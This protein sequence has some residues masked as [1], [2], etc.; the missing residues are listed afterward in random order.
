MVPTVDP[1]NHWHR[2]EMARKLAW[3][4]LVLRDDGSEVGMGVSRNRGP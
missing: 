4:A 2:R 1:R 3:Q